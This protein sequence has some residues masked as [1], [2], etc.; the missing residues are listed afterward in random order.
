ML[1]ILVLPVT[2]V[3]VF[4]MKYASSYAAARAKITEQSNL[5]ALI[6][7]NANQLSQISIALKTIEDTQERQSQTLASIYAMLR[8]VG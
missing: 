3:I 2:A 7:G 6:A 5:R 4:A 8:E 1:T